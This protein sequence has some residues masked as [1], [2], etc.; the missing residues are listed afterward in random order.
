MPRGGRTITSRSLP[1]SAAPAAIEL[2]SDGLTTLAALAGIAVPLAFKPKRG[3][4][5]TYERLR[6]QARLQK[7]QRES[8][9]PPFELLPLDDDGL[10]LRQLPEPRRATCS[11]ISRAIPS[12][13]SRAGQPRV[14]VRPRAT[15]APTARSAYQAPLGVHGRR[16]ARGV[17]VAH[18][19]DRG[20]IRRD[21]ALH[22]Y[23]YRAY[24]PAAFKR[25]M[26]RMRRARPTWI[27]LLRGRRFVDLYSVVA[28]R[29]SRRRR[30]LLD[31]G[32]R[33]LYGFD[34]TSRC[35]TPATNGG[36]SRS[37][38]EAGRPDSASPQT[39]ASSAS[40][41]TTAMTADPRSSSRLARVAARRSRRPGR[42]RAAAGAPK[43]SRR[44]RSVS[45]RR[46]ARLRVEALRP[47]PGATSGPLSSRRVI[48]WLYLLDWHCR[49][50]KVVVV[51]V[52][53]AGGLSDEDLLRRAR[54]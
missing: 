25:L 39:I 37:A 51:G 1:A 20:A 5:A 44:R 7:A 34:A 18:G 11:S 46:S 48:S 33:A 23:H 50:D 35:A 19:R 52:L 15:W 4:K 43:S 24:E 26:A 3:A 12:L 45:E 8:G 14:S 10:V 42:R 54:R 49:E 21:P 27:A 41:A 6:E 30:E 31:Q 36:S 47:F 53:P 38:L 22:I 13:R 28:S 2:E 9:D 17:R 32:S 16:R 40:R 29:A